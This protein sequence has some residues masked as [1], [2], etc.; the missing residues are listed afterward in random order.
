MS[1]AEITNGGI[2]SSFLRSS[3]LANDMPL[4]SDVF[5]VPPGYNAPQQVHIT[6]G[7]ME[8]KGVIVS[9]TTPH[10]PGSNTVLYWADGKSKR[11]SRRAEGTV[12]RYKYINYT[13]GYIHHCIIAGLEFDTKY[14]YEVGI[15]RIPTRRFWFITP[16]KPGPDVPYTFGL[17]GDLGQTPDSN[18]TVDHY[19]SN[20]RNPKAMLFVGDLSY[21]DAYPLGDNTRWDT[22]GRFT[23]R[24][25]AYQPAIWSAGNH[26]IDFLPQ[27]VLLQCYYYYCLSYI[28]FACWI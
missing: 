25:V 8:G 15:G 18:T 20:P 3:E 28:S 6:Q 4:D 19:M 1:L 22:W 5:S 11:K 9:W 17:I 16:P 27:Y 21:A 12:L 23:E 14:Y 13:S 26:D 24:L 2:T 7:D 10:E